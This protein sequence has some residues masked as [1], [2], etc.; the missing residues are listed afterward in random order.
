MLMIR[1]ARNTPLALL[2]S[3]MMGCGSSSTD[4][5]GV[6]GYEYR[7]PEAV[8]DG[9]QTASL[10]AVGLE[11]R[12][13]VQLMDRLARTHG[14]QLHSLLVIRDGKLVFEEYF[15]GPKFSL[16]AWR[17]ISVSRCQPLSTSSPPRG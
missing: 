16:S 15:P 12:P 10:Q 4:T 2:L 3:V 1:P 8:G 11:E 14:H 6:T 7:I 17:R 13:L 9:W 5:E